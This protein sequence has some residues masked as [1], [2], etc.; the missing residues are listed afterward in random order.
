METG[1]KRAV[2]H[3]ANQEEVITSSDEEVENEQIHEVKI[4]FFEK[5]DKIQPGS[6]RWIKKN[7]TPP[8]TQGRASV[9]TLQ[10]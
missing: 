7:R 3:K 8:I 6:T 9:Q 4:L 2:N 1:F 10:T 5:I